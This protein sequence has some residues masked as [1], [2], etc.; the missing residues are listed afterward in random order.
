MLDITNL[1]V[2]Y[3]GQEAKDDEQI[4]QIIAEVLAWR[5]RDKASRK[6]ADLENARKNV[7]KAL[8]PYQR[9][10]NALCGDSL[11]K[12]QLAGALNVW[13]QEMKKEEARLLN[14]SKTKEKS[15]V[16]REMPEKKR[17][18]EEILYD[19]LKRLY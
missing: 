3:L 19:F 16:K 6:Q 1:I 11:T 15:T 13:E 7:L 8:D 17:T 4:D 5:E 9:A 14:I 18:D 10:I 12:E 2:D